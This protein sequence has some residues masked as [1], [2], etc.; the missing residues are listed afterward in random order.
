MHQSVPER[1]AHAYQDAAASITITSV[2][3]MISF[4]VGII[5]PF[6]SVK[7]FCVYAGTCVTFTYLWHVTLFGGCMAVAG[8]AEKA[9]RH[10]VTCLTVVPKSLASKTPS[11]KVLQL[12]ELQ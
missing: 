11:V 5:T 10:A 3:D 7:I 1:L 2:T 6:P 4:W 12:F 9:N 8:Y